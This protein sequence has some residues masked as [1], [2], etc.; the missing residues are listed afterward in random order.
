[1]PKTK[2]QK[3]KQIEDAKEAFGKSSALVIADFT[4]LPANAMVSFR[5]SLREVGMAFKVVKKRLLK[6]VFSENKIGI[7]PEK[8]EGQT[9]LVFSPKDITETSQAVYKFYKDNKNHFKILGGVEIDSKKA[10]TDNEVETLGKLPSKEVLIGQLVGM[11]AVPIRSFLFVLN[12][13][14]KVEQ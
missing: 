12:E 11:I 1:M 13:K 14:S 7:D 10:L 9:G 3:A 2:S 4:G 6:I 5:K 8:L